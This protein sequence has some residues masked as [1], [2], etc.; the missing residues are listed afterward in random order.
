MY[1]ISNYGSPKINNNINQPDPITIE[2]TIAPSEWKINV[3]SEI[4]PSVQYCS[5]SKI[6]T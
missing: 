1:E 3:P 4:N 5:R 6:Q 2:Q